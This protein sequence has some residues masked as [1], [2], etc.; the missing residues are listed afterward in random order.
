MFTDKVFNHGAAFLFIIGTTGHG[1]TE[2][3]NPQHNEYYYKFYYNK[4]PQGPAQ[5][6]HV[7]EAFII[8]SPY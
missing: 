1:R 7:P 5:R 8:E 2:E 6:G 3:E 4:Y